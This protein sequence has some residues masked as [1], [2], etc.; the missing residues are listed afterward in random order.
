MK[1]CASNAF[2]EG[3]DHLIRCAFPLQSNN[4]E[5]IPRKLNAM[6]ILRYCFLSRLA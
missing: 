6:A 1:I 3:P 2:D 4:N 5:R